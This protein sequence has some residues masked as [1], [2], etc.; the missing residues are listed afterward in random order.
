[1][2]YE[3]IVAIVLSKGWDFLKKRDFSLDLRLE[4]HG[5]KFK[6]CSGRLGGSVRQVSDFSLSHDLAG[7]EFRLHVGLCADSSEPGACFRFRVSLSLLLPHSH[8]VS[9]SQ[10]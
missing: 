1:M 3:F 2:D 4:L 9:L 7:P 6:K 5:F 10:K 8:P